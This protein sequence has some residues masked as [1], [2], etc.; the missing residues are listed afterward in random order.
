MRK[1]LLFSPFRPSKA[2]NLA[3]IC[4][5][6]TRQAVELENYPNHP[7]I[8]QFVIEI[9]KNVFRFRWGVS[10]GE[11]TKKACFGNFGLLWLALGPNPL[12]HSFGSKFC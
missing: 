6:I 4:N 1:P 2:P 3:E 5:P 7:R 11:V 10:G 12:T 9:E 8:Q